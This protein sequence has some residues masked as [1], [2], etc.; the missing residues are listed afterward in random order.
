MSSINDLDTLSLRQLYY[1]LSIDLYSILATGIADSDDA[2]T[3][4]SESLCSIA[5]ENFGLILEQDEI[6]SLFVEPLVRHLELTSVFSDSYTQGMYALSFYHLQ[7][8][9]SF[10]L[11]LAGLSK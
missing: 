5:L 7:F 10:E 3:K 4:I 2:A 11:F 1:I 9:S 6:C 8:M